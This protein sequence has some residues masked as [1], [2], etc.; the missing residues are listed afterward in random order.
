MVLLGV[1]GLREMTTIQILQ[2]NVTTLLHVAFKFLQNT[3]PISDTVILTIE[4]AVKNLMYQLVYHEIHSLN[5]L[6]H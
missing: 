1:K 4:Q 3:Q 2:R 5:S 6:F